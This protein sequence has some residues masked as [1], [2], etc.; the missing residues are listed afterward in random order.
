M[1]YFGQV[2]L[3]QKLNTVLGFSTLESPN[4]VLHFD[5]NKTFSARHISELRS[6]KIC[7]NSPFCNFKCK[8]FK[9]VT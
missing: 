4:N 8:F 3:Q 6:D 7:K 1:S 5:C 9:I 2:L